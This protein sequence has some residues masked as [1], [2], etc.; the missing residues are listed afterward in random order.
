MPRVAVSR[1]AARCRCGPAAAARSGPLTRGRA[2]PRPSGRGFLRSRP[3]PRSYG[4]RGGTVRPLPPSGARGAFREPGRSGDEAPSTNPTAAR[5]HGA[6]RPRGSLGSWGCVGT[7]GDGSGARP[8]FVPLIVRRT[9]PLPHRRVP[10][11]RPVAT[12]W[13][14]KGWA[15]G[16]RLGAGVGRGSPPR[17]APGKDS[18]SGLPSAAPCSYRRFPLLC[19]L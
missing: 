3:V 19:D 1:R 5:G 7:R 8:Y 2:G 15:E 16:G 4:G 9:A 17:A 10:G 12:L 11:I 14:E 13:R 18:G 6:A